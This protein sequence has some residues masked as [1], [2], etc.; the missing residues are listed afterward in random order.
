LASGIRIGRTSYTLFE[1]LD[2]QLPAVGDAADGE[3]IAEFGVP[4]GIPFRM[5][6]GD[7]E[8]RWSAGIAPVPI[9][10]EGVEKPDG[11]ALGAT[12]LGIAEPAGI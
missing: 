4:A 6:S 11:P 10:E 2:G 1:V 5:L 3:C 8:G 9:G 7:S 12:P